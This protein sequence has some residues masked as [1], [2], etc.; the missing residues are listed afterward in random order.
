MTA[1]TFTQALQADV[2]SLQATHPILAGALD[3]AFA[4]VAGGHVFPLEDGRSAHVRSQSN[5]A[6]SHLVNGTCDCKATQ[7]HAAPCAHRLALRLYQ[8]TVEQLA[9]SLEEE[10][11]E[12]TW[13]SEAQPTPPSLPEAPASVNVR[14]QINGREVQWTLRDTDEARLAVRLEALLARYPAAQPAP[15]APSPL[16]PQQHN[17]AA[18][19][20]PVTGFCPVHNVQ[21]KENEKDG[22][23]WFSHRLPEGG[24]CKGK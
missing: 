13:T 1:L 12:P 21:M 5:P 24:F 14:L 16:S 2:A 7:Y 17:A 6:R 11:W 19:H 23:R 10:R 4:L 15:Q 3:K 18:M 20:H 9:G 8:R 22:R